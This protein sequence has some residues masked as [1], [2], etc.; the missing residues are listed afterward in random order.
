MFFIEIESINGELKWAKSYLDIGICKRYN[1]RWKHPQYLS[2]L[3][4]AL[5]IIADS[6][7]P[8]KKAVVLIKV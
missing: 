3:H 7:Y 4:I 8:I 1:K 5:G 2:R 6:I